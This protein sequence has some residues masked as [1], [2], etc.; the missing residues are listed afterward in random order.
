MSSPTC[1]ESQSML[2]PSG[3]P[4]SSW[5]PLKPPSAGSLSPELDD[6]H[7]PVAQANRKVRH[8]K[9]ELR[10]AQE[11]I[12][13]GGTQLASLHESLRRGVNTFVDGAQEGSRWSRDDILSYLL[14]LKCGNSPRPTSPVF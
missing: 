10:E 4:R 3:P 8:L 9:A 12:E 13:E 11:I 5:P 14:E 7:N 6:E 1:P 2:E